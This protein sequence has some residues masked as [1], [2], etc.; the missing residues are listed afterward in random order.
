M[1]I[2]N[3]FNDEDVREILG[4]KKLTN[5][6]LKQLGQYLDTNYPGWKSKSRYDTAKVVLKLFPDQKK[7]EKRPAHASHKRSHAQSSKGCLLVIVPLAGIL[8]HVR[9]GPFCT[10]SKL[11]ELVECLRR[12]DYNCTRQTNRET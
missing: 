5:K 2:N 8:L 3:E 1:F 6:Q 10:S 9:W 11:T 4:Y 12:S 7:A